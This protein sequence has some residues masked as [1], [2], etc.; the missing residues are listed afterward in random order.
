M[1]SLAAQARDFMEFAEDAAIGFGL[2]DFGLLATNGWVNLK[3]APSPGH[4]EHFELQ[5]FRTKQGMGIEIG[6]HAEHKDAT[7][8]EAAVAALAK[9]EKTW[10][11]VLGADPVLGPFAQGAKNWRRVSEVW[12]GMTFDGGV[13][14]DA[15]ERLVAYVSALAP[16]LR[17]EG[18]WS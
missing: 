9:Y 5:I 16:V 14:V 17:R 11:K 7:M 6:F 3:V 8:N 10:R 2:N 12:D 4:K 15:G 1:P 13:A 18:R